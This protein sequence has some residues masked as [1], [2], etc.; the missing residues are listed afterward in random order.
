MEVNP[1]DQDRP[2]SRWTDVPRGNY[3]LVNIAQPGRM[4]FIGGHQSRDANAQRVHLGETQRAVEAGGV[5]IND[6]CAKRLHHR[7]AQL[8]RHQ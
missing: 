8:S 2:Q 5:T 3:S 7:R 4:V 1:D 6:R